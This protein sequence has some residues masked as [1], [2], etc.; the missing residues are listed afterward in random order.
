MNIRTFAV[1]ALVCSLGTAAFAQIMPTTGTGADQV[2]GGA[3]TLSASVTQN[4]SLILP[5]A[6]ALHLDVSNLIFDLNK[7]GTDPNMACVY[8]NSPEDV[9]QGGSTLPLG[10]YYQLAW[11]KVTPVG[12][13]VVTNYPPIKLDKN[14]ELVTGSKN[15]FVCYRTFY[16][17]KFSNGKSFALQLSRDEGTGSSA[18]H[19][20]YAQ[21]NVCDSSGANTGLYKITTTPRSML[22]TGLTMGTTGSHT[23]SGGAGVRDRCGYKSWLDDLVVVA[24]PVNG[25][26]YGTSTAKLTYTLTT[27]AFDAPATAG[28]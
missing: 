26:T 21:D 19:N 17:Q 1:A 7:I 4:V 24:I 20:I 23:A 5:Q 10:T 2:G 9:E 13:G 6:T 28:S 8:A 15:Y 22:P 16:L 14:N 27:T 12:S 3:G 18:I 11:P 25:E